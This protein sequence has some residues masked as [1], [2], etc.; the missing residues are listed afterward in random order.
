MIPSAK[1]ALLCSA[2]AAWLLLAPAAPA[3]YFGHG[4]VFDEVAEAVGLD[5]VHFN[6]MSG[7]LYLVEVLG[8]GAALFD[9][10]NDGDLD[11][12][13]VQGAM[14][15]PGKTLDQATFPPADGK[16]PRDRLF[17]NDLSVSKEGVVDLRFVD[18]TAGSGIVAEG[19]GFA[20]MA[21]DYDNDGDLDLYVANYGPNQLWRNRGDGTF[22]DA[23]AE[24]G[25]DDPRW[26]TCA[27]WVDYDHDG[28]L[29][30]FVGNYLDHDFE[31]DKPCVYHGRDYPDYC[32]PQSIEPDHNALFRNRGDGTFEDVSDASGIL[33]AFGGALGIACADYNNDGLIDIYVAND[34]RA[35]LL[36]QNQGDGEF[37]NVSYS[38]GCAVNGAGKPEG[39][40]G[41]DAG[42]FDNDG[43]EDLFMLHVKGE[44]NTL[45]ENM[46]EAIF[47]DASHSSSLGPA[48]VPFTGFAT[49]WID[50]D[51]NG[52]LDVIAINGHFRIID[53]LRQ[54]GIV[55][56]LGMANQLFRN[57]GSGRFREVP[58]GLAGAS[59]SQL[60]VGRGAAFGDIDND[61]DMD[62]LFT[63]N[64]GRARLLLNNI[65]S[66]KQS[67]GLRLLTREGRD[68]YGAKVVAIRP[69]LSNLHRRV[70]T[71]GSYEGSNDPRVLFGLNDFA[72]VERVEVT[73]P[74]GLVE[75]WKG[76]PYEAYS[77]LREGGSPASARLSLSPRTLQSGAR[78]LQRGA[79]ASCVPGPPRPVVATQ[80]KT[81]SPNR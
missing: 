20:A 35:N 25:V 79:M 62:V 58:S 39:S 52:W 46:G 61:G 23:T 38:A 47:N 48:S 73:W 15:G 7:E 26:S 75:S 21:G 68:A 4:V 59:F 77:E 66:D 56:P 41:V 29:D 78:L 5:F 19:Y 64:S 1:L 51:N 36:W 80:P 30:L 72:E 3:Q 57:M 60:E 67:M 9:C 76:L 22:E 11:A 65:G 2:V 69:G 54:K 16:P 50:Y 14:L 37:L 12:Y 31:T 45:Y 6:G 40:M 81:Q 17:R 8:A 71:D 18:V 24:A 55:H 27:A 43:D 63:N 44:S 74:S 28:W 49:G 33:H 13:L 32:G 10:D 70:R 34:S 53:E 42:D